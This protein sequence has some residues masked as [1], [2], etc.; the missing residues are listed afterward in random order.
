MMLVPS[1]KRMCFTNVPLL[2]FCVHHEKLHGIGN[3]V[4][5]SH[6]DRFWEILQSSP[7]ETFYAFK[8]E[9]TLVVH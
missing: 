1:A 5:A 3:H 2:M 6:R 7:Q 4:V 9:V 8:V